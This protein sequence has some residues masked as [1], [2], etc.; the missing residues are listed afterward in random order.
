MVTEVFGW[1]IVVVREVRMM[2]L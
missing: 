2:S 1:M